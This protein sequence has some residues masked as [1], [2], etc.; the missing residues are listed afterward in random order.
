MNIEQADTPPPNWRWLLRGQGRRLG[1]AVAM[2]VAAAAVE[3]LPFFLLACG[4]NRVVLGGPGLGADLTVLAGWMALALLGKYALYTLAYYLSHV[5]AYQV[6]L[7]TRRALVRHLSWAPL[8]WLSRLSSGELKQRVIQDVE[9]MEQFIA[10]HSVEC[11]AALLSPLWV[12]I[13]LCFLDWRLALCALLPVPLAL[14]AQAWMMRG[15]GERLTQYAGAVDDLDGAVLEF[16]RNAPLMKAFRQDAR[17]FKRMREA[18]AHYQHLIG[19]MIGLTVPGWSVFVVLLGANVAV[20]FPVGIWLYAAGQL[21]QAELVLVLILGTGMLRPLLRV[22]RLNSQVQEIMGGVRRF[23]P[24]LVWPRPAH[25]DEHAL[26]QPLAVSFDAVSFSYDRQPLL[27]YLDLHL[28]AGKMTALVGPSGSGKSTLAWLLGGLLDADSGRVLLNGEPLSTLG[29]A[30][31]AATVGVVSQDA[32]IFQGSLLDNLRIG[33]PEATPAQI[34]TALHVAQADDFV[35]ALPQGLDT[36]MDE[37][38]VRLSGGERQRI[39]L[40]RALLAETP[41]LVLDEATAFADSRTEQRFYQALRATWPDK[42]LLVIAHRL[43][44]IRE[45]EQIVLL[46]RGTIQAQGTHAQL[47]ASSSTYATQWQHQ[48]DSEDWTIREGSTRH[49]RVD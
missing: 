23:A 18:L 3:L 4:V 5:A 1:L 14:L 35:R 46:E 8:P 26:R 40:A 13:A 29:E 34:A 37:R 2:A 38:G 42:T 30:A 10:H 49:A 20:L 27:Q 44:S 16:L 19:R 31:R 6:L 11:V 7:N 45:A 28:P 33:C 25:G 41:I 22:A 39:G 47:L 24:L 12:F 17:S 9:R 36:L 48:F 15:L 32:F 21:T 43:T